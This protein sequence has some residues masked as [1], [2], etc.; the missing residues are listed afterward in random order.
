LKE[1]KISKA[2]WTKEQV[3]NLNAFQFCGMFHPFTCGSG[4]RTDAD[5]LDGEGVL[6][7]TTVGWVCTYCEYKQSWAHDFMLS[8]EL[9]SDLLRQRAS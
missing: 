7:A 4:N 3:N 9:L 5:H 2:P 6:L 1:D 8:G